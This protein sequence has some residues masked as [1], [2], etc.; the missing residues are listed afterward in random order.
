MN[1]CTAKREKERRDSKVLW[2]G[3]L[4]AYYKHIPILRAYLLDD[5]RSIDRFNRVHDRWVAPL[6]ERKGKGK[7]RGK[8][9]GGGG[10][11][12]RRPDGQVAFQ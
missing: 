7:K 12:Y 9:R 1:S 2:V 3:V 5:N 8:K 10:G 6:V 11:R 4:L